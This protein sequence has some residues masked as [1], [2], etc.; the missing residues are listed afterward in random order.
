MA[1]QGA[2]LACGMGTVVLLGIGD[3]GV[4]FKVW[5]TIPS[6]EGHNPEELANKL[7]RE[8]LEIGHG[9]EAA[10]VFDMASRRLMKHC[11]KKAIEQLYADG[12]KHH[13]PPT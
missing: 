12:P 5:I 7:M 3:R 2:R 10:I 9:H 11:H 6:V 13:T 4:N 1:D 8:M